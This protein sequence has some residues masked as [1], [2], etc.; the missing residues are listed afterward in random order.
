MNDSNMM[1]KK[2]KASSVDRYIE[3]AAHILFTSLFSNFLNVFVP[4]GKQT[5]QATKTR[6]RLIHMF[7]KGAITAS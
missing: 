1:V 3:T 4:A 2:I 5:I 6:R 7:A